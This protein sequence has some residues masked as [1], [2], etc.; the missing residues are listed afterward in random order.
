M[1]SPKMF[2][3][4]VNERAHQ[5][6]CA[7]CETDR[8]VSI[9]MI[10]AVTRCPT[11]DWNLEYRGYLMSS[12]E[13]HT[14]VKLTSEFHYRKEYICIDKNAE[15]LPAPDDGDYTGSRIYPVSAGCLGEGSLQ[16]CPPYKA[17]NI[18]LSCV[19]CSR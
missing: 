7:A 9:M 6:P 18:A 19:V 14:S 11:S 16:N 15:T 4:P 10:P 5:V 8:R 3:E 17:D 12:A 13:R 1:F 2:G